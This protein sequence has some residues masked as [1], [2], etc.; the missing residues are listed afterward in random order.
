M[1]PILMALTM[2]F[3]SAA[4]SFGL[5]FSSQPND[6]FTA[7]A[8]IRLEVA[9][10]YASGVFD[11]GAA[12]ISAYDAATK[13]LFITNADANTLD[14]VSISNVNFPAL[15]FTID[16]SPYGDGVNSVA[17]KNGILAVAVEAK[18]KQD[19]GVV[20]FF[21]VDGQH[22]N[23]LTVG[24]LPD[25]LTFTPDGEK[26]LVANEG[27]PDDDYI[28]DPE[29]T[30]SIIDLSAGVANLTNADV[31][32]VGFTSFNGQ[33]LE[34]IRIFGPGAT[35]AEDLEPEYIAVSGDS[36]TAWV[37]LQENNAIAV[38]DI[39][40]AAV[41]ALVPL[42]TKDFNVIQNAIDA[43]NRDGRINIKPW[44]VVGMYQ[45]DSIA[46]YE[47]DG[48]TYLLIA[49]EGD[50][51]DY[52]GYSEEARVEDE[53]TDFKVDPAAYPN[54][55]D[56]KDEAALGRLNITTA[57]GDFD[58]DGDIDLLHAYGGRSFSILNAAGEMIYDSGSDFER[59]VALVNPENFNSTNDENDSFD[60]RS[61]DK[62]PE[63]EG[64]TVG[65]VDGR[66]Y[67]FI[68]FERVGGIVVYDISNP[69]APQFLQYIN[70]RDFSGDA[71]SGTAGDLG[72][73]GLLFISPDESPIKQPLLIVTNEVSGTT[74]IYR[75]RAEK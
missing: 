8:S 75:I 47:V 40:A 22:L 74:T 5:G 64:L 46:G 66:H 12:E 31:T 33:D 32:T 71:A 36:S 13:R 54:I 65:L 69:I 68:G 57:T 58:G 1:K 20:V 30:V 41:T 17:V 19:P 72:P 2:I 3:I 62:G 73:E 59:I 9:G 28:K 37:T 43:S 10:T 14:V 60:N 27:E 25:M 67:A 21:D 16:L 70:N 11:E 39:N 34:P 18:P 53:G 61:D 52:D 15:D 50:A 63:P 51:R 56:L 49:N 26:I 7:N 42:G 29:G 55:E 24:A 45:P 48:Q 35:V 38:I 6:N 4:S 44:P 23:T